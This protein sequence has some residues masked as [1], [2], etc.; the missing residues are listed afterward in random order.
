VATNKEERPPS[1]EEVLKQVNTLGDFASKPAR[2]A[3]DKGAFDDYPLH[4]VAIWGDLQ[5]AAVLL[6]HGAD[7]NA[8]GEDDDTPLHRAV[9]GGHPEMVK[10]LLSRGADPNLKN[11]YGNSA[12]DN[13]G[14]YE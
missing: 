13:A 2:T 11:R 12:C 4:K 5:A 8:R 3:S 14:E 1:L 9:A 7:L 6:D 10:F